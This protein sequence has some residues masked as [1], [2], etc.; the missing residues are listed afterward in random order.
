[1]G[2]GSTPV[3][4]PPPPW[5]KPR[6]LRASL[7]AIKPNSGSNFSFEL[8]TPTRQ[9]SAHY[10]PKGP[11]LS[12]AP[13]SVDLVRFSKFQ[14]F[15]GLLNFNEK[16]FCSSS[17]LA[18]RIRFQFAISRFESSRPSQAV[19]R[20][21]KSPLIVAEM[22]ANSRLLRLRYRSPDSVF[23]HFGGENAESLR[24]HA[25]LFPFS[26]DRDRRLV[27]INSRFLWVFLWD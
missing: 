1:V 20:S 27:S 11:F 22:P 10:S 25:G 9:G 26:G 19:P 4:L 13:D 14:R 12:K 23:C 15:E 3:P 5:P 17:R 21:E 6:I 2:E 8:R 18:E 24:P 16:R 7:W